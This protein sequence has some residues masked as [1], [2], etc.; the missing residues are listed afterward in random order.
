[1]IKA[2]QFRRSSK[3]NGRIVRILAEFFY[4]FDNFLGEILE[5]LPI[6]KSE[7]TETN[8]F[9]AIV[10][11]I[12]HRNLFVYGNQLPGIQIPNIL[13]EWCYEA[14]PKMRARG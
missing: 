4:A 12:I 5:F 3:P 8:L 7:T 10:Y 6:Q 9:T 13:H 11:L 1:M 14:L 2:K